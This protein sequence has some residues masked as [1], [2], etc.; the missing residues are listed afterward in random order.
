MGVLLSVQFS[1]KRFDALE[2][3]VSEK[4]TIIDD[5]M[6]T[7]EPA[8]GAGGQDATGPSSTDKVLDNWKARVDKL[9]SIVVTKDKTLDKLRTKERKRDRNAKSAAALA[10]YLGTLP[11]DTSDD[12]QPT[13]SAAN[14]EREG[15]E[16]VASA[17]VDTS[18][19]AAHTG[20][21]S[22]TGTV[23]RVR[24]PA[25]GEALLTRIK[26]LTAENDELSKQ[27]T[28]ARGQHS[29]LRS[30]S[31]KARAAA[32]NYQAKYNSAKTELIAMHASADRYRKRAAA[33]TEKLGS[34]QKSWAAEREQLTL[35]EA[36]A[37]T[38]LIEWEAT[39]QGLKQE[40]K[41]S[42]EFNE[43]LQR[44]LQH[45]RTEL[46]ERDEQHSAL[47]RVLR[48]AQAQAETAE[49]KVERLQQ[50]LQYVHAIE[51][52]EGVATC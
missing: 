32:M 40:L 15:Q 24:L 1:L 13:P 27:W 21:A 22:A 42:E 12:E 52:V 23:K 50:Q 4:S 30:D 3:S 25:D 9:S 7:K 28:E 29:K 20:S 45:A 5:F 47:Q 38:K 14:T 33:T 6:A 35:Q 26:T 46:Q 18:S 44:T 2:K 36:S 8:G 17:P 11:S 34:Y 10:A 31:E 43:S 39:A 37:R 41:R 19:A 16:D 48:N 51:V 49:A